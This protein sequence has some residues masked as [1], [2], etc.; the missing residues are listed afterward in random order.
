MK[1][2]TAKHPRLRLPPERRRE[3]LLQCAV[4]ACAEHGIARFTHAHIADRAGISVA[5]VHVYFRT[6]TDLVCATLQSV[7]EPLLAVS[8]GVL[9][10]DTDTATALHRMASGFDEA[11][12][13]QP[14]LIRV[15]LDWSTG[16]QAPVWGRYLELQEQ[17]HGHVR[18][19]LSR[20][21]QAGD[22]SARLDI[23]AAARLFVGGGHTIALARLAGTGDAEIRTLIDQL[24]LGVMRHP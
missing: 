22:V 1:S 7:E 4:A 10:L 15:W 24:V 20:G 9:P 17:V 13:C 19:L 2:T 23:Q 12:R 5:A 6:R 11:A 3:Q 8:S 18:I 21:Q 16:V 14:D